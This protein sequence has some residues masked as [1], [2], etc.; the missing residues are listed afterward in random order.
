M[1]DVALN[2]D[3][4]D[5]V[6][7]EDFVALCRVEDEWESRTSSRWRLH[8]LTTRC[9]T[10]NSKPYCWLKA[11]WSYASPCAGRSPASS[12]HSARPTSRLVSFNIIY[13]FNDSGRSPKMW[14]EGGVDH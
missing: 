14:I 8:L 12:S 5:T 4:G 11:T 13:R 7:A 2:N 6:F 9:P 1:T 10:W 3:E